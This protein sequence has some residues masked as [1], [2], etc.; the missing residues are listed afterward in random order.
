MNFLSLMLFLSEKTKLRIQLFFCLGRPMCKLTLGNEYLSSDNELMV[1]LRCLIYSAPLLLETVW[2]RNNQQLSANK[3]SLD[4]LSTS[5]QLRSPL[6]SLETP[7]M[8]LNK[9]QDFMLADLM[10][11][12]LANFKCI[13]RNPLGYSDS[14]ELT[15][16]D[17]QMLLSK[18][19]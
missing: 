14:C 6:S 13:A 4:L 1:N 17:K 5:S 7:V 10:S 16:V 11:T 12:Q 15:Q 19:K 8:I 9:R 2:F 18:F 3:T